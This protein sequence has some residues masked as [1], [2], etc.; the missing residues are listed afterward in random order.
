MQTEAGGSTGIAH[1]TA[2][3]TGVAAAATATRGRRRFFSGLANSI[4]NLSIGVAQINHLINAA[5]SYIVLGYL[6]I[7]S[8]AAG[9]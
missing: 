8:G 4:I 2:G 1:W 7:K 3:D 9:C 6:N 5:S